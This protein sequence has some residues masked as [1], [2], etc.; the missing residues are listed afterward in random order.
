[1]TKRKDWIDG[2]RGL[3]MLLVIYGHIC[4]GVRPYSVFSQPIKLPLFFAVTGYVFSFKG[5][6]FRAFLSG[7]FRRLILPWLIFSGAYTIVKILGGTPV[8]E[9]LMDFASGN[10]AWYIPC[11]IAAQLIFF[12]IQKLSRR[13]GPQCAL[14]LAVSVAGYGVSRLPGAG[15]AFLGRAMI[16]QFYLMIGHVFRNLEPRLQKPRRWPALLGIVYVLLGAYVLTAYSQSIF[17]V[18]SNSYFEP[19]L[20]MLMVLCGCGFLF[21]YARFWPTP[22]WLTFIGRNTLIFYLFHARILDMLQPLIRLI[23]H[24]LRSDWR[25]GLPISLLICALLCAICA[26]CSRLIDRWLPLLSG[27]AKK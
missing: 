8:G 23:P 18:Q 11:L 16:V 7:M 4:M 25:T 27:K 14:M 17:D 22:R 21:S 24:P 1:M 13:P 10:V 6:D 26:L 15:F 19:L 5:G 20:C 3:A 2:L 9:A 12:G